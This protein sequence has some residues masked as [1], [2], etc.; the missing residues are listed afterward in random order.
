MGRSGTGLGMAAL[1]GAV[2]D[3][4]GFIDYES[5]QGQGSRFTLYFPMT[6]QSPS[7]ANHPTAMASSMGNGESLLVVDDVK[8]QREIASA[9]LTTLGDHVNSVSS[10]ETA[11]DYLRENSADPS[12]VDGACPKKVHTGE[13]GPPVINGLAVQH[14]IVA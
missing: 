4:L 1:L 10:G 8:E 11:V 3:H 2:K 7:E 12:C 14:P 9:I 6:R 5:W 13:P